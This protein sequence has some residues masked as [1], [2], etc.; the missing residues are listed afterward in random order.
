MGGNWTR[1]SV[2]AEW[3]IY[4]NAHEVEQ[5]SY[6]LHNRKTRDASLRHLKYIVSTYHHPPPYKIQCI[7]IPLSHAQTTKTLHPYPSPTNPSFTCLKPIQRL[8]KSGTGGLC[9]RHLSGVFS[10]SPKF[11]QKRNPRQR[12]RGYQEE[13]TYSW[14]SS[15]HK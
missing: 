14:T 7:P 8:Y 4:S 6:T 15:D 10:P 11:F 2:G 5:N 9:Q 13:D 3:Y 12:L 1:R